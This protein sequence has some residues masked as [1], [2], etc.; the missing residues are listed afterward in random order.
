M[1]IGFEV[2]GVLRNTIGKIEQTYQ[3]FLIEKTE[4]IE[5]DEFEYKITYP[6]EIGRAHV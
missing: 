2:N 4:G 6:L 3:K 1:K 5:S